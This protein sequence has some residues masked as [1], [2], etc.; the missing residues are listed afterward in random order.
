M[1]TNPFDIISAAQRETAR[2][3]LRAAFGPA[4]I[5]AIT[6]LMGGVSGAS[7]FRVESRG[8]H[9]VLRMEGTAS[10]LRNPHQYAS[11]RIAAEAGIA[12]RL[13]YVDEGARVA[14]M[15]FVAERP[16]ETYPDGPPALALELGEMLRRLQETPKF[17]HFVDYPDIVSLLWAHVCGTGLFAPGVL[18]AHTQRLADIRAAYLWNDEDS[19]SSHNDVLPRNLLFDG[20][21]LWL[22]DWESAY[23]NDPLI[24]V[25]I[26]LDNFAP[27]AEMEEVLLQ[28]CLGRAPDKAM[29]DRLSLTRA[30]TR[31]YYAGVQFSAVALAPRLAPDTDL[32][33]PTLVEF[34]QALRDGRLS[35][36][37]P[38]TRHIL[39]KMYLAAF[40]TGEKPP[41]LP[42]PISA[43]RVIHH[44]Q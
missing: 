22:V 25:G 9:Y 32:A 33:A 29:R 27:S 20:K 40:F 21:R 43:F 39:G 36:D 17:A 19:V 11:M 44:P 38:E 14:L 42:P 28:A 6:S 26:V 4:P 18:D 15:D 23:R 12:P 5:G 13:H 10:P 30:L 37:A 2:I 7:V 31:L 16:L 8:R 3:A 41:G 1:I 34:R 35:A 24:D